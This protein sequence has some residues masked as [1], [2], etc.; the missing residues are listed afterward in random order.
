MNNYISHQKPVSI[1]NCAHPQKSNHN[2][3][4]AVSPHETEKKAKT[5]RCR[6]YSGPDGVGVFSHGAVLTPPRLPAHEPRDLLTVPP[7][8]SAPMEMRRGN[9]PVATLRHRYKLLSLFP[10]LHTY[11]H[12]TYRTWEHRFRV[13]PSFVV[14]VQRRRTMAAELHFYISC[15]PLSRAV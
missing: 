14:C 8:L 4:H 13:S 11:M 5:K 9:Q 15:I 1:I 3:T 2:R 12:T 6:A 10:L 7:I